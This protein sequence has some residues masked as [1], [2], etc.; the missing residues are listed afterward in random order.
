M[1]V[2]ILVIPLLLLVLACTIDKK[3][4]PRQIDHGAK[5]VNNF[6][7]IKWQLKD[8][9]DYPYRDQMLTSIVYNDTIRALN[10]DEIIELL[11]NPDRSN[12][13]YLYYMVAQKRLGSWPLHT[14]TL[15]IKLMG[16]GTI[17]WIK[18]H[19]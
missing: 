4:S 18:I 15:V 11:G 10:G 16:D 7:K 1:R 8:G 2:I 17:E 14:K 12:E 19:E 3:E 5:S 9:M 6:D 13:G